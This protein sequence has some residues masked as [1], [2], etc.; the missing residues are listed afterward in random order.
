MLWKTCV[1]YQPTYQLSFQDR[2]PDDQGRL[3]THS[4]PDLGNLT[5]FHQLILLRILRPDRLPSAMSRYVNR[6]LTSVKPMPSSLGSI[7][8]S[9]ERLLGVM[10]L[11]PP[12]PAFGNKQLMS[13]FSMKQKPTGILQTIAQVSRTKSGKFKASELVPCSLFPVEIQCDPF[14]RD[15]SINHC[16]GDSRPWQYRQSSNTS[17]ILKLTCYDWITYVLAQ[18]NFNKK[19][20][21]KKADFEPYHVSRKYTTFSSPRHKGLAENICLRDHPTC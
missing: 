9:S 20:T 21:K 13:N 14:A 15:H 19:T 7:I 11:L 2:P 10:I 8:G 5:D 16:S 1:S 3:S 12:T 17:P 6:H 18:W 4:S